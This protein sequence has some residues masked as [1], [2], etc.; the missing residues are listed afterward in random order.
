MSPFVLASL[1][2]LAARPEPAK[3]INVEVYA[4]WIPGQ[5]LVPAGVAV[6]YRLTLRVKGGRT[7]FAIVPRWRGWSLEPTVSVYSCN[8]VG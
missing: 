5:S 7:A 8:S 6:Q 4:N 3:V 1:C 2:F